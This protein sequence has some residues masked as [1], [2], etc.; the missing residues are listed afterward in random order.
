MDR[1]RVCRDT[2][3][4][5]RVREDRGVRFLHADPP[6]VHD[7]VER[8]GDAHV[9]Q[10]AGEPAFGV[11]KHRG[12]HASR[13]ERARELHHVGDLSPKQVRGR[14]LRPKPVDDRGIHIDNDV[15]HEVVPEPPVG[16]PCLDPIVV[17]PPRLWRSRA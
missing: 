9:G 6:R 7:H 13:A 5:E 17:T 3:L 11:R 10:Q 14:L 1:R 15:T 16:P 4:R 12:S 8:I 2:E